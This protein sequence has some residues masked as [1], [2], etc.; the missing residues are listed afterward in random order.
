MGCCIA[1]ALLIGLARRAWFRL[2]PGSAAQPMLF[3]P[4]ARRAA[5]GESL[6]LVDTHRPRRKR[7]VQTIAGIA[8]IGAGFAWCGL[9]V[10]GALVPAVGHS[11]ACPCAC[12]GSHGTA[13][14]DVLVHAPGL[15]ATAAG[16]L[17]LVAVRL[18]PVEA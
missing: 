3:A 2:A 10:L 7:S 14:A 13:L 8:M 16:A 12:C 9:T 17:L 1:L 5:P 11:G 6:V 15:L 4:P 18:R